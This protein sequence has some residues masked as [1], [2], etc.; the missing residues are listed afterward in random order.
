MSGRGETENRKFRSPE[1]RYRLSFPEFRELLATFF[2]NRD[3]SG[4][5]AWDFFQGMEDAFKKAEEAEFWEHW[6]RRPSDQEI[7]ARLANIEFA[8][9]ELRELLTGERGGHKDARPAIDNP[10]S[11]SANA[12]WYWMTYAI[13]RD[14]NELERFAQALPG[15][16]E[17]ALL[18]LEQLEAKQISEG[19]ESELPEGDTSSEVDHNRKMPKGRPKDHFKDEFLKAMLPI[20]KEFSGRSPT[21]QSSN[22]KLST[23]CPFCQFCAGYFT[24]ARI[25]DDTPE[26]LAIR[27]RRALGNT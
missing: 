5:A 6:K 21:F 19:T 14:A 17:A 25:A 26:A 22:D 18:G 8:A 11:G 20:W 10:S 16:A 23:P 1:L 15:I 3:L 12:I 4:P 27:C 9:L 24:I 2:P 13:G 7:S